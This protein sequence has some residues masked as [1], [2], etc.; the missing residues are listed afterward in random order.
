M[1]DVRRGCQ[2]RNDLH[3]SVRRRGDGSSCAAASLE[4]FERIGIMGYKTVVT[5]LRPDIVK[6]M[7]HSSISFEDRAMMK[8]ALQ[9]A[10]VEI[11]K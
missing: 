2:N 4:Y 3:Q 1:P 9:Q 11:L 5:G 8:G 6:I 7:I 10:L